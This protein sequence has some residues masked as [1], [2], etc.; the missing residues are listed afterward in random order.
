MY[1]CMYVRICKIEEFGI[2]VQSSDWSDEEGED[3]TKCDNES[4]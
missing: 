3:K 4:K 2:Q 1:V